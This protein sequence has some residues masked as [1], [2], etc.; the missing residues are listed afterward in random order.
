MYPALLLRWMVSTM[1]QVLAQ[2]SKVSI[3]P[4]ITVQLW[5]DPPSLI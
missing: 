2:A 1:S 4:L 3:V 5:R